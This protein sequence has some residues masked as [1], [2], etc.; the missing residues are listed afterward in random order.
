MRHKKRYLSILFVALTFAFLSPG[1]GCDDDTKWRFAKVF[2]NSVLADSPVQLVSFDCDSIILRN[3]IEDNSLH[4]HL[5]NRV[6]QEH[7]VSVRFWAGYYWNSGIWS[8]TVPLD[9]WRVY[10]LTSPHDVD[11]FETVSSDYITCGQSTDNGDD[12]EMPG[13]FD[14]R[15]DLPLI[16]F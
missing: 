16:L 11:Y 9:D 10:S 15:V 13:D 6:G 8:S 12:G 4:A 5:Q 1:P 3:G 7:V 14:Y 2:D